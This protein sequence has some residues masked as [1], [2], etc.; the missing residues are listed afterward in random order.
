MPREPG[1]DFKVNITLELKALAQNFKGLY[2]GLHR[3][4][5]ILGYSGGQK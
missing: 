1:K 4:G 2:H 3:P 5:R